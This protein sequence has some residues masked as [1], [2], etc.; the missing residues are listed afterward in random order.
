MF[1][2]VPK[3]KVSSKINLPN[4]LLPLRKFLFE[5]REISNLIVYEIDIELLVLKIDTVH[6]LLLK[7][8]D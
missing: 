4:F 5:V 8:N 1:T 7:N 3:F 6:N 2:L